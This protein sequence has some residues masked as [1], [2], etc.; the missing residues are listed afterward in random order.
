[1]LKYIIFLVWHM[2]LLFIVWL[3]LFA[4]SCS[5]S[6][7]WAHLEEI[8]PQFMCNG[9]QSLS[10]VFAYR[11]MRAMQLYTLDKTLE[12]Y[13]EL[14]PDP[15]DCDPKSFRFKFRR[16]WKRLRWEP[17]DV[18]ELRSRIN[19]N[20][21]LLNAFNGQLTRYF[22]YSIYWF[23]REPTKAIGS[24]TAFHDWKCEDSLWT[25]QEQARPS[26]IWRNL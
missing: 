16:G 24:G 9:G 5:L 13:Q 18:K 2:I 26:F 11:T 6:S 25:L 23:T 1:M 14:G 8:K 21:S 15:K 10:D 12:E 3:Y 7:C 17:E 22:V 4:I 20:I 19:S